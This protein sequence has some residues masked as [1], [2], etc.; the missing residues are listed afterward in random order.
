[1]YNI[2]VENIHSRIINFMMD[3]LTAGKYVVP[4][5][6]KENICETASL[7]LSAIESC[8]TSRSQNSSQHN[9]LEELAPPKP[10][11]S[12]ASDR[13]RKISKLHAKERENNPMVDVLMYQRLIANIHN[14]L[15]ELIRYL[16]SDDRKGIP[17]IDKQA[18]VERIQL[19]DTIAESCKAI[20]SES[21]VSSSDDEDFLN[22]EVFNNSIPRPRLVKDVSF[23]VPESIAINY[24]D[25]NSSENSKQFGR[26]DENDQENYV[27]DEHPYDTLENIQ[28]FSFNENSKQSLDHS[29]DESGDTKI[30]SGTGEANPA[31]ISVIDSQSVTCNG[32][33][34]YPCDC[35]YSTVQKEDPLS[36]YLD[37]HID[38]GEN[39]EESDEI[40]AGYGTVNG[41]EKG[42]VNE[43][44][45]KRTKTVHKSVRYSAETLDHDIMVTSRKSSTRDGDVSAAQSFNDLSEMDMASSYYS[46]TN[47][48]TAFSV[49]EKIRLYTALQASES[50]CIEHENGKKY[51]KKSLKKWL[52][53]STQSLKKDKKKEKDGSNSS[54]AALK[55]FPPKPGVSVRKLSTGVDMRKTGNGKGTDKKETKQLKIRL[56]TM[57]KSVKNLE[58]REEQALLELDE[59]KSRFDGVY[60]KMMQDSLNSSDVRIISF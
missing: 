51:T 10:P 56:K 1:M 28:N 13:K 25:S 36:S 57:S 38:V 16:Y 27:T 15:L 40:D 9:S 34:T 4:Q 45:L 37:Y 14:Q 3:L 22:L 59:W 19:I 20:S 60:S 29:K 12:Y 18:M 21:D 48:L 6:D 58:R 43:S 33:C 31:D 26:I 35:T 53:K 49:R 55:K 11:R 5:E 8:V 54:L 7:V 44:S 42:D 52:S 30:Y 2:L 32:N 46:S 23:D 24:R 47:S 50:G 39:N 41:F 17:D